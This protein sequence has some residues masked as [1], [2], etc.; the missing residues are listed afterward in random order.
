MSLVTWIILWHDDHFVSSLEGNLWGVFSHI[1]CQSTV[2]FKCS[3]DWNVLGMNRCGTM[4]MQPEIRVKVWNCC[5]FSG[6]RGGEEREREREGVYFGSCLSP[7]RGLKKPMTC[8]L[9]EILGSRLISVC[10]CY[11]TNFEGEI[12]AWDMCF[13]WQQLTVTA[14]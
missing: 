3:T 14:I 7:I 2:L 8:A 10:I 13:R 11:K 6:G 4:Q 1:L 12:V 5:V 9:S